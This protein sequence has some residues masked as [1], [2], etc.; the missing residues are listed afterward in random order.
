MD[1]QHLPRPNSRAAVAVDEAAEDAVG[2]DRDRAVRLSRAHAASQFAPDTREAEEVARAG[3]QGSGAALPHREEM[4]Q[5]FGTSFE[6]VRA[7]T[8][9]DA[10][11]A[12]EALGAEAFTFGRDVGFANSS[13]SPDT[14]AHELTHVRQQATRGPGSVA[15][16][17][18]EAEQAEARVPMAGLDVRPEAMTVE[19]MAP[20]L[21]MKADP[22]AAGAAA[23]VTPAAGAAL[24]TDEQVT[25]AIA[26][27]DKKWKDP[28]RAQMLAH[29]RGA[30]VADGDAFGRA[31]VLAVARKQQ[32]AGATDK[33]VDG[34]IGK[35]TA[36]TLLG[37]GLSLSAVPDIKPS[38]VRLVF[39]PG[40]FE[41]IEAWQKAKADAAA[42][43]GDDA[44]YNEYRETS[45]N[46]PPGHGT[47][48]VEVGGNVIDRID[49]RGGPPVDLK[50]GSHT[51]DPS[52]AGTYKLGKG[53]SHVTS[54]W[55]YSQIAWGAA[56]REE[57]GEI[58][59]K[60]PG[61]DWADATGPRCRLKSPFDHSEFYEGGTLMTEWKLNDFGE[62][63]FRV[64]GSPGLFVHTT[65][66]SE[67][68]AEM[69]EDFQ[70]RH[71]HGCLHVFPADRERMIANGYMAKGVTLVIKKYEESLDLNAGNG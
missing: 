27:N 9:P 60:N 13:P 23:S 32:E 28:H 18:H 44:G 39:Y 46:A 8:G 48:Y 26:F 12:S 37:S 71:S 25:S 31:D 55:K 51:A 33:D 70:L 59:F 34:K 65:P 20:A 14:V 24:L 10:A 66:L 53:K 58:Q 67:Q 11:A 40:E 41:D 56:I 29:L 6:G 63:A 38:Q 4:E 42:A 68:A 17:E 50:D 2:A 35:S 52:K 45:R 36:A 15:A 30:A 3:T 49:A 64:E 57:G 7:H 1:R 43:H 69:G 22:E 54:S 5:R 62:T 61:R 21:R 19:P 16:D 47:I